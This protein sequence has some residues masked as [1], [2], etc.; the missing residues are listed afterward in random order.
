MDNIK[1]FAESG[2]R[3]TAK[4]SKCE[5]YYTD[6]YKVAVANGFD[7]TVEEWLESLRGEDGKDGEKGDT[8]EKGDK[9]DKGDTGEKGDKGD[10]GGTALVVQT[11]GDS[12]TDVMSQKAV[13]DFV[14]SHVSKSA[15]R[16]LLNITFQNANIGNDGV[17]VPMTSGVKFATSPDYIPVIGGETYAL[18]WVKSALAVTAYVFEYKADYSFN[19]L[20]AFRGSLSYKTNSSL[21]VDAESAFVRIK[22]RGDLPNNSWEDL[23]PENFQMEQGTVV[24]SYVKPNAIDFSEIDDIALANRM[25]E[26]GAILSTEE[27]ADILPVTEILPSEA[28]EEGALKDADGSEFSSTARMRTQGYVHLRAGDVVTCTNGNYTMNVFEYDLITLDY[29]T[30]AYAWVPKYTVQ[31]DCFARIMVNTAANKHPMDTI[32]TFIEITRNSVTRLN[33]AALPIEKLND[34]VDKSV[35]RKIDTSLVT[36]SKFS[37]ANNG[38]LRQIS[39]RGFVATG[40]PQCTAPAYIEAKKFGYDAGEN[41]LW[42]TADGV[43]VMAHAATLPSDRSV[44]IAESTYETLYAGNMGTFNGREVKIMTFEEWLILMKKI[45]LEA[46]VD[47]KSHLT[48]EQAAEAVSIVRKHGM[49]DKV[50]WSTSAHVALRGIRAAHPTARLALIGYTSLA[51]D[52]EYIIEDRPDLT[53]LY[54]QSTSVTAEVVE[55]AHNAGVGVECWHVDYSA[56]GF[57]TEEAI[58]AEIERVVDL[59]V[60]GICLDT[61]LPCE[62]FIDKLNAEW[63][64]G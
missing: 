61:Y 40:A 1:G 2:S 25:A 45:G 6:A 51:P 63:G 35:D 41:D 52:S 43:F 12:E 31:N 39:H 13:T 56:H 62:Y 14:S 16:N 33:L 55:N 11:T 34:L 9:G 54:P 7:G 27:C 48:T 47:L 5:A 8:G 64:L 44:V 28:W 24:T 59:G 26:N 32:A 58:F 57:T 19:R 15:S 23:I 60:T 10:A 17:F 20:N 38:I 22:L 18:S 46:F 42:V 29:I 37:G 30:C 21:Q 53:V 50:T 36:K 3:L 49:L 4:I